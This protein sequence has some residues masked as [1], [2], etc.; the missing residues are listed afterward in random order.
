MPRRWSRLGRSRIRLRS[1]RREW[2]GRMRPLLQ[3]PLPAHARVPRPSPLVERAIGWRRAGRCRLGPLGCHGGQRVT[4]GGALAPPGAALATLVPLAKS[5]GAGLV[6]TASRSKNLHQ[7]RSDSPAG[8][9]R[10][11]KRTS[12]SA[13]WV[14]SGAV[15][16][17]RGAVTSQSSPLRRICLPSARHGASTARGGVLGWVESEGVA[18]SSARRRLPSSADRR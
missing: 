17:V 12:E 3:G 16:H 14:G 1:A 8:G 6:V 9:R 5:D 7:H 15:E 4:C 2:P 10:C 18:K 11:R 13:P